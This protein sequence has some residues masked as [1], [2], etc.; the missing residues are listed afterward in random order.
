MPIINVN[1]GKLKS[2]E[3][4]QV[5]AK[6]AAEII[7]EISGT[8]LKAIRVYINERDEESYYNANPSVIIDWAKLDARTAEVK[9]A[10]S[11][12]V[13]KKISVAA[14]CNEDDVVFLYNNYPLSDIVINGVS[15]G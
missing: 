6:E 3:E 13:G 4:K 10:I 8:P 15:K 1:V 5:L 14:G 12:A 2:S 7:G 9:Q 11:K